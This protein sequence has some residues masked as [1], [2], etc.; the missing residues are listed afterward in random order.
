MKH[1][2]NCIRCKGVFIDGKRLSCSDIASI[3]VSVRLGV[4]EITKTDIVC[5]F[6][7]SLI[8]DKTAETLL[9]GGCDDT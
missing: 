4:C 8:G 6:C 5:R 3:Y 2:E 7:R 1:L 9:K